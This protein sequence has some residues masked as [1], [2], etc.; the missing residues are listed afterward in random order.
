MEVWPKVIHNKH[1]TEC[2]FLLS[3]GPRCLLL[4]LLRGLIFMKRQDR[5]NPYRGIIQSLISVNMV[6]DFTRIEK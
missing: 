3:Q 2:V 5:E 4:R 6:K 1:H